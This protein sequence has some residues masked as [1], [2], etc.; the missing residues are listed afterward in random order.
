MTLDPR[1]R[2]LYQRTD[3][4][5]LK[6]RGMY[7]EAAGGYWK[8]REISLD[9]VLADLRDVFPELTQ[10][11]PERRV[12]PDRRVISR[13]TGRRKRYRF[14]E[15]VFLA[16]LTRRDDSLPNIGRRSG[17]DRRSPSPREGEG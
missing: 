14:A 3:R 6:V 12:G 4:E 17:G 15:K 13:L 7:P 9:L 16:N 11:R 10:D 1:V 8:G 2:G 5:C